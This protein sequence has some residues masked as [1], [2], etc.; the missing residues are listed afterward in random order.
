MFALVCCAKQ[1]KKVKYYNC[2]AKFFILHSSF[3]FFIST[4]AADL[5]CRGLVK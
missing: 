4:F 5:V 3:F 1:I 2:I